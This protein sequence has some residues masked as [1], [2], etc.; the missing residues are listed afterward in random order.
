MRTTVTPRAGYWRLRRAGGRLARALARSRGFELV[1]PA[2]FDIVRRDF[3]SP[4]PD[5]SHVP[6]GI[7][8]RRSALGGIDLR[9]EEALEFVERELAPYIAE[10]AAPVEGPREPGEFYLRNQ[11]FEF[12]DA[13]LTYAMVRA[14]RPARVIELGSGYS[15]LLINIACAR[16][17][18]D[19]VETAHE[20]FD[21]YP[22]VDVIPAELPEPSR[23]RRTS[24]TEIP[25]ASFAEL[26]TGDVL[27]VDTTHTVKLGSDVNYVVLDVLPTLAPGVVVHFHDIFLP[28][29]YPREWFAEVHHYWAEQYLLQAFLAFNSEFEVMIPAQLLARCYPERLGRV[30][31]SF[32]ERPSPGSLWLRR[33]RAGAAAR[34]QGD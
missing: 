23:L 17:G 8:E 29:E 16:N 2:E 14:L 10:L 20:V 33:R 25:L 3:Y 18:E 13:E 30:I 31:P 12:V 26:Q 24:A 5:L 27:F 22:R 34:D 7:W 28:W 15:T 4:V 21:P 19:G 9:A 6:E 11:A 1:R 32:A